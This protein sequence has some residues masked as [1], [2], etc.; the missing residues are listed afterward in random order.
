MHVHVEEGTMIVHSHPFSKTTSN[1]S[2]QHQSLAEILFLHQ[3][4]TVN[5]ADS[6]IYS[7]EIQA[8]NQEIIEIAYKI[9]DPFF[10]LPHQTH[11]SLRGPPYVGSC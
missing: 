6:F 11:L 3:L 10:L 2:H 9:T 8:S 7:F 5:V 1:A 4:S